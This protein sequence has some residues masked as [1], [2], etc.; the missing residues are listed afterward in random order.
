MRFESVE[1]R[2]KPPMISPMTEEAHRGRKF[3]LQ[4]ALDLFM[5][6]PPRR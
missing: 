2:F 4:K 5:N 3:F 1:S 6:V